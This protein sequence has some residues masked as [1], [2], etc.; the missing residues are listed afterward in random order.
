MR[1]KAKLAIVAAVVLLMVIGLAAIQQL[2]GAGP[3]EAATTDQRSEPENPDDR[4]RLVGN[5]LDLGTDAKISSNYT[6]AVTEIILYEV[7]KA[8]FLVATIR[9]RYIGKEDGDLWADLTADYFGADSAMAGESACRIELGE[10][11]ASER[12]TL[13]PGDTET[14]AV[15]IDLP[16][17]DIEDGKISVHEAFSTGDQ[18]AWSTSQATTALLPSA[19]P[20]PSPT[21][22]PVSGGQPRTV[23][24]TDNNSNRGGNC[25]EDEL[26]DYR[27]GLAKFDKFIEEYKD[28]EG[29]DE[30]QVEK[31]EDWRDAMQNNIERWEAAC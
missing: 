7:P 9:A 1:R 13:A 3:D 28:A 21:P 19:A 24:Q 11:D 29:H 20:E 30:D 6:V 2:D 8:A 17:G 12:P 22:G 18:V 14:F 31:Y 26:D 15:C 5:P 4:G 16:T 27:D 23:P 25:D 10:L